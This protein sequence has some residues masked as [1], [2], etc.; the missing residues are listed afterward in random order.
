MERQTMAARMDFIDEFLQLKT[1]VL[2]DV[3][4]NIKAG[5]S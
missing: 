4:R 5:T 3:C 2:A 1:E